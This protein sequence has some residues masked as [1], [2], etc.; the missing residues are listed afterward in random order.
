MISSYRAELN[1]GSTLY[2]LDRDDHEAAQRATDFAETNHLR[3]QDIHIMK[4]YY[5][6]SIDVVMSLPDEVL[7]TPFF[8]EVLDE[9]SAGWS[10]PYNYS[11]IIRSKDYDG[12][13]EEFAYKSQAHATKRISSLSESAKELLII[14]Q[15]YVHSISTDD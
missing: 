9:W 4:D 8:S 3:L 11:C 14:T 5:P 15:D 1:D 10:L 13:V 7:P 2:L 12:N 6:H